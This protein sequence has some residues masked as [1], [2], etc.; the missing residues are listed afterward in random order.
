MSTSPTYIEKDSLTWADLEN[1]EPKEALKIKIKWCGK[2]CKLNKDMKVR[3]YL[4]GAGR[5]SK[6]LK[7]IMDCSIWYVEDNERRAVNNVTLERDED[8][9]EE[10]PE[11]RMRRKSRE[12][13]ERRK[14]KN[15]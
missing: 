6:R 10:T 9:E 1:M 5:G 2:C 7:D 11:E 12:R 15:K 8:S 14:E 13:R 3:Q 4:C